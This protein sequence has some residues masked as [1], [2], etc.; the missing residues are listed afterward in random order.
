[1]LNSIIN[2][3]EVNAGI[4]SQPAPVALPPLSY[5]ED[6]EDEDEILSD[7]R[8]A[9]DE[10][11][12]QVLRGLNALTEAEVE[13]RIAD[14]EAAHMPDEHAS[15]EQK[16]LYEQ[17]RSDF[18]INLRKLQGLP[19]ESLINFGGETKEDEN[20]MGFMQSKMPSNPS[21]QQQLQPSAN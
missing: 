17:K 6:D 15:E 16:E 7:F 9:V 11:K 8:K 18:I 19:S 12:E 14:F 13:R 4:K 3:F 5:C 1:M 10:Y 2:V 21:L 20:A